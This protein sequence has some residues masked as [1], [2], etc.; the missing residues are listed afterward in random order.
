MGSGLWC[1]WPHCTG[2]IFGIP[3]Y[4]LVFTLDVLLLFSDAMAGLGNVIPIWLD[5]KEYFSY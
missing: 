2:I 4:T 5:P 1:V 3:M